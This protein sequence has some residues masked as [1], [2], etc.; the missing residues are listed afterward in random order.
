MRRLCRW[1]LLLAGL[2]S[3]SVP[4]PGGDFPASLTQWTP[5]AQNPVFTAA[6]AGHWDVKIRERGW[7][8][9]EV[10]RYRMW[11]TGYDGTRPGIKM[12]GYAE[13]DDGLAWRRREDAPLYREH[14]VE[15]M[16]VLHH[17]DTYY[18]FAEGR[19]DQAH[20]LTSPDG[21]TWTRRGSLDVRY[22]DGRPL[23]AGPY[24][25]PTVWLEQGVWHLFY[26]RMDAGIWLATSRDLT[27]WT[28]VDDQPVL[29]PGPEGYDDRAVAFNQ[30][31]RHG[32]RY[33]ALY[34]GS[35]KA[36]PAQWCTCLAS[37][38]D[39]RHWTKYPQNPL[40]SD[41][42]SSGILVPDGVGY[43][44]YTMHDLVQ[45]HFSAAKDQ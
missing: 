31:V 11:Y 16:Q 21:L 3:F 4:A 24:G 30:I 8:L 18:M 10:D 33:Y 5:Y 43:R 32:E 39:L 27:V 9:H 38:P 7:I 28:N 22:V 13:S 34:H 20:L 41:N 35:G 45:A 12:L 40:L 25:T 36:S 17:G 15:D 2:F 42:K 1:L 14:W 29:T 6:G 37:S 23:S 19:H 44:L 26:E